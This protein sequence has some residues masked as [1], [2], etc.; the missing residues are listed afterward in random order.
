LNE[1]LSLLQTFAATE[2]EIQADF[3]GVIMLNGLGDEYGEWTRRQIR[4]EDYDNGKFRY[5]GL[6]RLCKVNVD[7][8][9]YHSLYNVR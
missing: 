4:H 6:N 7:T 1:I 9:K 8:T 5:K 2:A 3:I